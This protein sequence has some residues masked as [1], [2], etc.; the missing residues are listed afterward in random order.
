[1]G[2]AISRSNPTAA[3][4]PEFEAA[5]KSAESKYPSDYRFTYERAI[6]SVSRPGHGE[7]FNL[8]FQA[9]QKAIDDGKR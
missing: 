3:Q 6:S 2:S 8:L 4:R 9:G 5:L 7:T 1:M